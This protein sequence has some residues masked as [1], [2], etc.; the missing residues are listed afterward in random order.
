[1]NLHSDCQYSVSTCDV[2]TLIKIVIVISRFLERQTKAKSR[3]KAY[4]QALCSGSEVPEHTTL[5]LLA[6]TTLN[7]R[8]LISN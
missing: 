5:M 8:L 6:N 7:V 3:E 2:S 1:M 4:S